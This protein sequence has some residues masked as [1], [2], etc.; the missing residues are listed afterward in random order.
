MTRGYDAARRHTG[1]SEPKT[2]RSGPNQSS[3]RV[4]YGAR[5][6]VVQ[7]DQSA[8]V[9]IPESLQ[10][11]LGRAARGSRAAAH[12]SMAPDAIGRFALVSPTNRLPGRA[13]AAASAGG[14]S[15][16]RA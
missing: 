5:S 1:Q 8:S 13:R 6:A 9:T 7:R 4:A 16:G 12:A 15:R 2:Q 14:S 11:T 3:T 10:Y